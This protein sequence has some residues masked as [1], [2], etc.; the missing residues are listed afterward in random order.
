M[1]FRFGEK[2]V[3]K[4]SKKSPRKQKVKT[5]NEGESAA[6]SKENTI[7]NAMMSLP[8][9]IGHAGP[10]NSDSMFF[11]CIRNEGTNIQKNVHLYL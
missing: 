3:A 4:S 1:E 2:S 5:V 7:K 6:D 9:D 11:P 10:V 8:C